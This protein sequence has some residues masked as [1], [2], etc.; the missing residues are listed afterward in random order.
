MNKGDGVAA[1]LEHLVVMSGLAVMLAISLDLAAGHAG[2]LSIAHAAFYGIGAYASAILTT[3]AGVGACCSAL[4]GILMAVL[5]SAA[6]S[7]PAARLHRDH[8]VIA[9]FGL[10]IVVYN[11]F[12][13]WQVTTG[14][15][16]GIGG[17]PRPHVCWWT[18]QSA[19][20]FALLT[21]LV[22]A[23][24]WL[25][26]QRLLRSP[27]GRLLH[28]VRE[29]EVLAQALGK[30]AT[31]IRVIVFGISC[32]VA[33]LAGSIYAHYITYIDPTCFTVTDSVMV[34]AMV[35]VGGAG[36]RIG[37]VIGAISLVAL[38]EALRFVGLPQA[39]AA[40][41]RQVIFGALLVGMMMYRPRGLLG[42]Y[43]FGTEE[44]Q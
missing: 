32:A 35:I 18:L 4:A 28:A 21:S 30:N 44:T 1:Y 40:N 26:S 12:N 13:N 7:W 31:L 19:G 23:I 17:I 20:E 41:I 16:M 6:I 5:L 11:L 8:F 38:P 2:L 36:S 29:D 22:C 34:V 9:T 25:G 33:A 15:S 42:R 37:P 39:A 24:S 43:E 10:Q 27:W 14:G 3:Q